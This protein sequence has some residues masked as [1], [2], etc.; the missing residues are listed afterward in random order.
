MEF[1]SL[2]KL[3]PFSGKIFPDI[4]NPSQK[5][6][7]Y[8]VIYHGPSSYYTAVSKNT[9][10]FPYWNDNFSFKKIPDEKIIIEI[11]DYNVDCES[12]KDPFIGRGVVDSSKCIIDKKTLLWISIERPKSQKDEIEKT[13]ELLIEIEVSSCIKS[14]GK[15]QNEEIIEKDGLILEEINGN[16]PFVVEMPNEAFKPTEIPHLRNIEKKHFMVNNNIIKVQTQTH[17]NSSQRNYANN[18]LPN[19]VIPGKYMQQGNYG[20][21]VNIRPQQNNPNVMVYQQRPQIQYAL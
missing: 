14:E 11:W 8:L 9:G 16:V 18:M 10:K 21:M 20:G 13:C 7:P 19:K 3:K 6:D 5:F 17:I 2:Y 4:I 1:P 12:E 15:E